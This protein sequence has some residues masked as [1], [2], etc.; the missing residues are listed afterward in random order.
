MNNK[1]DFFD[2]VESVLNDRIKQYGKPDAIF[3]DIAESWGTYKK[4]KFTAEDVV[5]FMV[6]MKIHRFKFNQSFDSIVDIAGYA[7]IL[8]TLKQSDNETSSKEET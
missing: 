3:K 6:L 7:S 5:V 2:T 8:N 1:S 4:T